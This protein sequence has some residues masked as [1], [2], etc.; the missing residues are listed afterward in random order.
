MYGFIITAA[1][2]AMLA[3]AAAGETLTL[4]GI[5]VGSGVAESSDEAKA[6]T[7]LISPVADAISTPA[8]VSGNQIT[9]VVEYRNDLAEDGLTEGFSLREFGIFARVGEDVTPGLLYYATLADAPQPVRPLADGLQSF[10]FPVAIAVTGD[11]SVTLGYP[12]GAFATADMLAGY[13]PKADINRPGG[14]AGLGQ[15]GKIPEG[16]LP[17]LGGY[18]EMDTSIPASE[19][20]PNTLYGLI[21]ANYGGEG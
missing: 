6:L 10:R 20:T 11:V 17:D 16:L 12:A 4:T 1:G 14:V 15:D 5:R 3:R 18:V 9:L 19:R 7:G 13:I 8:T 2:E 21:I